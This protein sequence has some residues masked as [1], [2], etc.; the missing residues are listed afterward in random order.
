MHAL[1]HFYASVL[2]AAGESIKA[3]SE[4]LGHANPALTLRVYAHLMP[5]SQDRTRRAV[6]AVFRHPDEIA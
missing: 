4:Y 6:D 1:R 3:V 5:S 2:L